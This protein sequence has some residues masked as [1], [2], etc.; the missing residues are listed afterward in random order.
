[1][2]QF[3]RGGPLDINGTAFAA[4]LEE[5]KQV[6]GVGYQGVTA[7][8]VETAQFWF[9]GAG[10]RG[11]PAGAADLLACWR[12]SS[13]AGQWSDVAASLLPL[14]TSPYAAADLL[15]R[16]NAAMFD[17]SVVCWRSKYGFDFW[18]PITAIRQGGRW[19]GAL[20]A[21]GSPD[22]TWAPIL[23]PTPAHPEHPSGHSCAGGAAGRILRNY[24]GT[25]NKQFIVGSEWPIWTD[26]T[27]PNRQYNSF[28][29][30]VEEGMVSRIYAGVHYRR[31]VNVGRDIGEA[32]GAY[33]WSSPGPRPSTVTSSA[34]A[35]DDTD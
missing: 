12:T 4:E 30:A 3:E 25:D 24:W 5:V 32:V 11:D 19:R 6:G 35:L 16:L 29:E 7:F 1:M 26:P 21:V 34:F 33:V 13:S 15:Y 23:A 9:N 14:D 10:K 22:A 2:L 17:A 8:T 20:A 31:A 28:T 27:L 18:R